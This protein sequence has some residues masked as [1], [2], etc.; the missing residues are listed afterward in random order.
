MSTKPE[1][2]GATPAQP[3]DQPRTP[4]DQ[5]A[6]PEAAQY[7]AHIGSRKLA[8]DNPSIHDLDQASLDPSRHYRW[9]FRGQN[10]TR[11]TR[12][13]LHG[14]RVERT[15]GGVKTLAEVDSSGN[16]D[17]VIGDTVLMSRSKA[18]HEESRRKLHKYN[19][20]RLAT[21]T[22]ETERKAKETAGGVGL[23]TDKDI[24]GSWREEP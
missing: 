1:K 19:E 13:K 10:G 7:A 11:V 16:G 5:S 14:F 12:A 9:V 2:S 18:R 21:V 4:G 17:I 23:I 24:G 15:E 8:R 6:E 20:D 3:Q 22:S